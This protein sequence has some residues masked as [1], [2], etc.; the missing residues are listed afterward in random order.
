MSDDFRDQPGESQQEYFGLTDKDLKPTS[1][2]GPT[3]QN[4]SVYPLGSKPPWEGA[5]II[6]GTQNFCHNCGVKLK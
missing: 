2:K 5:T 4:S 6:N 1:Y 3:H